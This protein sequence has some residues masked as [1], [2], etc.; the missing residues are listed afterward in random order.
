MRQIDWIKVRDAIL[1]SDI[2]DVE[3]GIVEN[4]D[5]TVV[6]CETT[7]GDIFDIIYDEINKQL[8]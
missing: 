4:P 5:D 7:V 3:D 2:C 1:Y 6:H 8:K